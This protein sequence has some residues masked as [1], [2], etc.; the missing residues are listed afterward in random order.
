MLGPTKLVTVRGGGDLATGTICRL[1]RAGFSLICLE[2]GCPTFIRS[3][4]SLARCIYNGNSEVEGV[5]ASLVAS[6]AAAMAALESG[7][8]PFLI[9]PEA[10]YIKNFKPDV[11]I[12]A[13][14]AKRNTGTKI[15]W[16]DIVIGLGPGFTA[17]KD[18]HAVIE[19]QRGH[20]LGRVY[21]KGQALPNTG[22]PGDIGGQN[23]GRLVKAPSVGVFSVR[24]SIGDLI[25]PGDILGY[26][27]NSAVSATISGCLRGLIN[28]GTVVHAGM[29]IGDIDPRGVR[30][31][32]W[33]VS[34]K[35]R[36]V[37]GGVLEAILCLSR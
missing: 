30:E 9:D 4:V 6:P 21:Y 27:G 7:L 26:V 5:R 1:H 29:K 32:C 3:T 28:D 16:A 17:G 19:T 22:I 10:K 25:V 2:T 23:Y 13:I 20:N 37:A 34:E 11:V 36:A 14:M 12:D 18:V 15:G 33:S 24:K 8:V 35:A 31:H